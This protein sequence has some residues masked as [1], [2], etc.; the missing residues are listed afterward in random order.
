MTGRMEAWII[1]SIA[2]AAFQTL[3]FML[4]KHL[5]MGAL[6][7]GGATFARFIYSVPFVVTLALVYLAY[8]GAARPG[9]TKASWRRRLWR[10]SPMR[11]I[12]RGGSAWRI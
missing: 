6:S 7:A 11:P 3:R 12:I 2:A 1:L 5:S 9:F 10:G 4:Q 8:A